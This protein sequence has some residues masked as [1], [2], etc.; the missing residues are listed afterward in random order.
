MSDERFAADWLTLREPADHQARSTS[1]AR[2]ALDALDRAAGTEGTDPVVV[3]LGAGTGSNARWLH[4]LLTEAGLESDWVLVDHDEAL[5]GRAEEWAASAGASLTTVVGDLAR[6]GLAQAAQ[7]DL[8]T[9]SALL[10]LVSRGWL[11]D[12]ADGAG[13]AGAVV[14]LALTYDGQAAWSGPARPGDQEVREAVNRHQRRDKGVG[15][16]LGPDATAVAA[17]AFRARGFQVRTKD[18]PWVL[19]AARTDLAEE[20]LAGW[21]E[22]AAEVTPGGPPGGEDWAAARLDDLRA[23]RTVLRVGHQDLLALPPASAPG[24]APDPA[25]GSDR[26]ESPRESLA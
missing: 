3:D 15:A 21:L 4:P 23:G 14:L 25:P 12:L 16:A 10:D 5:L 17:S 9:A 2:A 8:L 20:L 7:A 18:T 6:E 22:A 19:D 24:S 13:E 26:P 11:E 1:L